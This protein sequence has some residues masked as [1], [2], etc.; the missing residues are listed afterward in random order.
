MTLPRWV[1]PDQNLVESELIRISQRLLRKTPR[2]LGMLPV[3]CKGR[4][5]L[6]PAQ[7]LALLVARTA[8]QLG[9]GSVGVFA[10]WTD[11]SY[12]MPEPAGDRGAPETPAA[13]QAPFRASPAAEGIDL[14]RAPPQLNAFRAIHALS[15]GME[16]AAL[17]YGLVLADLTGLEI[18]G[19]LEPVFAQL[20]GV[21]LAVTAGQ[22]HERDV[23]RAMQRVP[24][25]KNWGTVLMG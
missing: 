10:P 17:Q 5:G 9:T 18:T 7:A 1:A 12:G 8:R 23:L 6:I 19:A 24:A 21:I 4:G 13:H 20:D 3:V 16:R 25:A 2:A 11:W 22:A 14:L 15:F